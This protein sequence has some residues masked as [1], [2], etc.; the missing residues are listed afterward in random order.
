M[1]ATKNLLSFTVVL[2][3]FS[4]SLANAH[5]A[6]PNFQTEDASR[7]SNTFRKSVNYALNR[8][9]NNLKKV[10]VK[11]KN[12]VDADAINAELKWIDGQLKRF[13]DNQVFFDRRWGY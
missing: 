8:Y 13:R 4:M 7:T 3:M 2:C 10:R 11:P 1:T 12:K 6:A 5:A 9:K